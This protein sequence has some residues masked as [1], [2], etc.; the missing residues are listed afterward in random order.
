[1]KQ[2]YSSLFF[3]AII[4]I[5]LSIG[6]TPQRKMVYLQGNASILRDTTTFSMRIYPGDIIAVDLYTVNP[7]AFPGLGIGND[8]ASI[9]D[10][11][12]AYEKGFMLDR[13]GIVALPYI[14]NVNLN[15]LTIN[16]AHDT[17]SNR[18][19]QYIDDPVVIVKKLSFKVSVIGEVTKPGL[20]YVPNEQLTIIEA[21]AMAG[22]LSTYADR[23][24]LK[25]LRKTTEGTIEIPVDLTK[26]EAFVGQSKYM[27]PDDVLYVAPTRKKAFAQVS[28]ATG[29]FTSILSTLI[30]LGTL[31]VRTQ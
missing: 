30:L 9:I 12:S 27:Y 3:L 20:F 14:G 17:I 24:N 26:K 11:R 29:V 4:T 2:R 5:F 13:N 21:L 25:I 22:D 19:K 15:G 7:D 31:Y 6:C 16:D 8:R 18:F 1:M 10:N 28:V 23:T